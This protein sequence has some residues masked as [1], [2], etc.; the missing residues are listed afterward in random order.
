MILTPEVGDESNQFEKVP[1]TGAD[2]R[3]HG[4]GVPVFQEDDEN[5][6]QAKMSFIIVFPARKDK[7]Y[8]SNEILIQVLS[9]I[10]SYFMQ[11]LER[12]RQSASLQAITP[13][14]HRVPSLSSE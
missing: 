8:D 3:N 4:S 5:S 7:E 13:L 6:V 11:K 14:P 12:A 1:W 10:N 9:F 2:M